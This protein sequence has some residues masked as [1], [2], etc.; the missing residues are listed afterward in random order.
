MWLKTLARMHA[1]EP[2][3]GHQRMHGAAFAGLVAEVADDAQ[4]FA[5]RRQRVEDGHQFKVAA[6]RLGRPL[7]H[8]RAMRKIEEPHARF[9]CSGGVR[10]RCSCGDHGI[11]QR[12]GDT[13]AQA[14]Q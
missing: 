12:Q 4:M 6:Y 2:S 14:A 3:G 8:H 11:E 5:M 7:F 9:G 1:G 10:Q 13:D